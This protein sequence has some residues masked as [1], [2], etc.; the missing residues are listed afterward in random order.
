MRDASTSSTRPTFRFTTWT[1]WPQT[2]RMC[3]ARRSGTRPTW[4]GWRQT[5]PS[6]RKRRS[7]SPRGP[8]CPRSCQPSRVTRARKISPR[9]SWPIWIRNRSRGATSRLTPAALRWRR[10]TRATAASCACFRSLHRT[11]TCMPT[12][13]R[14][15][16]PP[17]PVQPVPSAAPPAVPC[18][19]A[20]LTAPP[21]TFQAPPMPSSSH[22]T[23]CRSIR[24][25]TLCLA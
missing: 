2:R 8:W 14:I 10:N 5:W 6:S 18:S 20:P 21:P 7:A 1:M 16:T 25:P 13:A 12:D 3:P 9:A 19:P 22:A 15:P 24:S 17:M 11:S 4:T 23:W